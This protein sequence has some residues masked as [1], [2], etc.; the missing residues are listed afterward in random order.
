MYRWPAS[1]TA[2]TEFGC[3]VCGT[4]AA[5]VPLTSSVVGW[6]SHARSPLESTN[7]ETR[8]PLHSDN[9]LPASCK[10]VQ[11]I[12]NMERET[13]LE[14]A[15]SSL[16]K[17]HIIEPIRLLRLSCAFS[18]LTSLAQSVISEIRP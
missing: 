3:V 15:T 13:G 8:P 2:T 18:T 10:S 11:V 4:A 6:H 14:P 9:V 17:C 1:I 7:W 16:G 12:E 5:D